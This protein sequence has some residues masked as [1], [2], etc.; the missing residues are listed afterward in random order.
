VIVDVTGGVG[1]C[2]SS[3]TDG[4]AGKKGNRQVLPAAERWSGLA[5]HAF[6]PVGGVGM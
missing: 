6:V 1:G 3:R 5:V 2:D 4:Q